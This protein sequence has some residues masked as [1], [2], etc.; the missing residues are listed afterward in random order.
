MS[1]KTH[2]YFAHKKKLEALS[3]RDRQIWKLHRK[4]TNAAGFATQ[5]AAQ[6]ADHLQC[7]YEEAA[8]RATAELWELL[9]IQAPQTNTDGSQAPAGRNEKEA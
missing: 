7:R 8:D 2:G 3:P 9:T 1:T 6:G 4:A 5:M